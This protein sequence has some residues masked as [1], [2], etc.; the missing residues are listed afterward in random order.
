MASILGLDL[1]EKR[2]GVAF[3]DL[4]APLATPLE[5]LEIRGKKHLL[6]ELKRIIA[7]YDVCEIV[8]GLPKTLQGELG[9]AALNVM[10]TVEWL[11]ARTDLTWH[12]WDERLTTAEVEKFLIEAD[13]SRAQRKN[14][15]DKLAAQKILQAYLDAQKN[16]Q[17]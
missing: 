3:A 2:V 11:K 9:P 10:E 13:V 12:F 15:R 1:G 4:K 7:E 17:E 14:I 8:A 5:T 16:K 6:E